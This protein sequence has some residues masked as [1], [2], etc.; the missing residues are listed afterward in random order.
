MDWRRVDWWDMPG[1]SR[2]VDKAA[3][4]V[5][6][7]SAG[8]IGLALPDPRPAGLLDAL[9]SRT[10][11]RLGGPVARVD[12]Q[13][14]LRGRSAATLLAASAGVVA[15]IRTVED[16]VKSAELAG[17]VFL[18][19]GIG[20]DDWDA[21][22]IFLTLLKAERSR[23][24]SLLA[25]CVLVA[26]P[27][28]FPMG[29][30]R[31]AF[32]S[33]LTWQ[34]VVS[35]IDTEIFAERECAWPDD[36]LLARTAVSV[37]VELSGWDPSMVR[38]L[39]RLPVE[40]QIDPRE[41]LLSVDDIVAGKTPSWSNG[42]VDRWDGMTFPHTLC[43]RGKAAI[44]LDE[45]IWRA[46][47]RT[48]F[49]F[50]DRIRRAFAAKYERRIYADL[51]L[52]KTFHARQIVYEHPDALELHDINE[53]LRHDLPRDEATLL[54]ICKHLRRQMA[55]AEPGDARR[56]RAASELWEELAS[57]FPERAHAWDWPRCG[58]R[59]VLLVGP[60]GAGKSHWAVRNHDPN[61]IVSSDSI[62]ERLF[63]GL[64]MTG[65]QAEVFATLRYEASVRLGAGKSAVIDATNIK[66]EDR[67]LNA[68]LM[69]P[70]MSVEYV[71]IDR[72]MEEK[73]ASAGWRLER[74]GLL[75]GHAEIFAREL[76]DILSGD[77]RDNVTVRDLR[78]TAL[79]S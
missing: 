63:G 18:V 67:L 4:L 28:S 23:A 60:S 36:D 70:D 12:A 66:R 2:F 32:G 38:S 17:Q 55:H 49:P 69:P 50:L 15:R 42:L 6:G 77:G 1:P 19:D 39:S 47:V 56:I 16:F 41:H 62:R 73:Q 68:S 78:A 13:V 71:I 65:D 3:D 29:E 37:V 31:S 58:Q 75:S 26:L 40:D 7:S 54:G 57:K 25:P 8:V 9:A 11:H 45:R 53:V 27:P 46:H 76:A 21:W 10:E 14:G 51:P 30:Y 48:V 59:L 64:M 22:A 24:Q 79:R 35:R 33:T 34:G 72:S 52:V 61:E 20:H 43:L 44:K 74:P 5:I